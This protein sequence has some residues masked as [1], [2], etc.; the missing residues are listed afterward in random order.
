MTRGHLASHGRRG[1][2]SHGRQGGKC[3]CA[4]CSVVF[5]LSN[6]QR[7]KFTCRKLAPRASVAAPRA[8]AKRGAPPPLCIFTFFSRSR[9]L[10]HYPASLGLGGSGQSATRDDNLLDHWLTTYT[11]MR[12]AK[13][14]GVRLSLLA[15]PSV[16]FGIRTWTC[17]CGVPSVCAPILLTLN[18]AP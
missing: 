3:A 4:E 15:R 5:L 17:V 8:P 1:S 7:R 10:A 6:E 13:V 11:S 16:S 18:H 9:G 2:R 12:A 14:S